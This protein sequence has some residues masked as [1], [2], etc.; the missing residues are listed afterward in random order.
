[1]PYKGL[2]RFSP[3]GSRIAYMALE[4]TGFNTY[5]VP[6]IGGQEPRRLLTNGMGMNWIDDR[7][8]LFSFMTGKGITHGCRH[9]H[10]KSRE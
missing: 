8:I 9:L 4:T 5:V 6:V 3:D 1:V 7:N 2:P 10:R